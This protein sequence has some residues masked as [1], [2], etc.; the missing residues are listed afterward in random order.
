MRQ[1]AHYYAMLYS[2]ILEFKSIKPNLILLPQMLLV[3]CKV[4]GS[5]HLSKTMAECT[6]NTVVRNICISQGS[7]AR[8]LRCDGNFNKQFYRK[9]S[10][11]CANKKLLKS[12]DIWR[13]YGQKFGG[14]CFTNHSV[15]HCCRNGNYNS[16]TI[17]QL[18]S[19][20]NGR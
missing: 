17:K 8:R 19:Q 16:L 10:T 4:S 7:V 3:I 14:T 12:V 15:K 11:E 20:Y 1:T 5:S 18:L 9:L 6:Q 13:R 2:L